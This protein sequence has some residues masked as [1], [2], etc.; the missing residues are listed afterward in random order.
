MPEKTF[1]A[2]E[3]KPLDRNFLFG[4]LKTKMEVRRYGTPREY[5]GHQRLERAWYLMGLCVWRQV[6][7]T[8]EVPAWAEIQLGALGSTEWR[9]RFSAYM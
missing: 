9:S 6:I 2:T 5:G 8:E 1:I 4:G 3:N 7:D